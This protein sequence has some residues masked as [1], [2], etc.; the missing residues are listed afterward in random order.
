MPKQIRDI[1]PTVKR[2]RDTSPH[3]PALDPAVVAAALGGEL[4]GKREKGGGPI[5]AFI[6]RQGMARLILSK[7]AAPPGSVERVEIP[8][9]EPEWK[10]LQ[11]LVD[12]M[13]RKGL[14]LSAG[15]VAG[16]MLKLALTR[17]G[18]ADPD[19]LCDEL[20]GQLESSAP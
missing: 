6:V 2:I 7:P 11:E 4:V 13:I 16:A 1:G 10:K 17:L 20:R 5:S 19:T 18:Q 8:I 12:M 15:Q 14:H 9:A 3:V